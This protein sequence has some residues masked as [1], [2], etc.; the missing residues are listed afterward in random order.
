MVLHKNLVIGVIYTLDNIFNNKIFADKAIEKTLKSNKKWGSKDRGFIAETCYEIVR[1][2]RLYSEIANLKSPYNSNELW[3]FFS[4]WAVLRG[5]PIPNWK[6]FENIPKRKIKGKFDH[7]SKIRKFRES[8]PNWLD[9]IGLHELGEK[10][11]EKELRELNKSTSV[12]LRTNTHKITRNQLKKILI[13]EGI[14]TNTIKKYPNALILKKRC[15]L[16]LRESFKKGL[17][18][19]Q[20]ASSQL[21]A[22]FLNVEKGMRVCDVCAGAGGKTLHLSCLMENKGKII[23]MDINQFKLNELRKRSKRN[24]AFNIQTKLIDNLKSVKKLYGKFDRLLIDAPCSG[25]GVLK[26]N[27]DA[28]WKLN[29]DFMQRVRE[30]QL[31]ILK[32]YSPLVKKGGKLV[33]ATCSILPSEN[34]MQIK[35]FLK[36]EEGKIFDFED[37]NKINPS[38]GFDGFYMARLALKQTC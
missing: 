7:L 38:D 16:F 22:P 15:N 12:V 17:Y 30:K 1:W 23:A 31:S 11:W 3:K 14:E 34:E 36:S 19:L 25:L 4:V 28:K 33:Y 24:G 13:N 6:E 21:V 27:P 5:L 32:K 29:L 10:K 18:E 9:K 26:R 20:D 2:K 35:K 8:I 37:E